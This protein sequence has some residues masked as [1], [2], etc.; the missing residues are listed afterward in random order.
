MRFHF[1][2]C[3]RLRVINRFMCVLNYLK[4]EERKKTESVVMGIVSHYLKLD[5][6]YNLPKM[7]K[8][9]CH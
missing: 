9:N 4:E 8:K 1:S 7:C 6:L 2:V 5:S 3:C